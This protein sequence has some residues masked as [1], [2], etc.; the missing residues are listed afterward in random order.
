[1]VVPPLCFALPLATISFVWAGIKQQPFRRQLWKPYHWLVFGQLLFFVA[2][3]AVGVLWANPITNPTISHPSNPSAR[4]CLD[5]LTYGSLASCGFWI[6]SM[7]GF[8]WCATSLMILTELITWGALIV[9][10]MAVTGDWL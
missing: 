4:L 6:W 9:A 3:I 7:K 2:A 10:G 5:A 8:R 1:M